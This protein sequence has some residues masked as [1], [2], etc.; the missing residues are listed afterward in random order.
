M[1]RQRWTDED[2]LRELPLA[3]GWTDLC[4]R[5]GLSSARTNV[6]QR[7][8]TLGLSTT[9]FTSTP[10]PRANVHRRLDDVSLTKLV[11]SSSGIAEVLRK[12]GYALEPA[13]VRAMSA[14]VRRL[15]LDTGHFIQPKP[16][17]GA[18]TNKKRPEEILVKTSRSS[19][20]TKGHQLRRAMIE[21][22]FAYMCAVCKIGPLWNGAELAL[23]VDHINGDSRDSR[24]E[25]VR[26]IC[27]NCHS[28]THT[29][30]ART[31]RKERRC[32]CG[33]LAARYGQFCYQCAS[34]NNCSDRPSRRKISWPEISILVRMVEDTSYSAAAR[35]LGVSDNA[36]RKHIR[37]HSGMTAD[38]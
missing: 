26:F 21:V 28:Q 24:I 20:R 32:G 1:T 30:G 2:L 17:T 19:W 31:R 25:N 12:G 29:F 7:V 15:G 4:R 11:A 38:S 37:R 9:H 16:P 35:S 34:E 36:V 8:E 23:Q 27:P 13:S 10:T 14:R 5:L 18:L 33:T 6:R 3:Q 22:G